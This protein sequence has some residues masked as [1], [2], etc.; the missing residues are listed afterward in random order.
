MALLRDAMNIAKTVIQDTRKTLVEGEGG[1]MPQR[2]RLTPQ[3]QVDRF[4]N[5]SETGHEALKQK[6]GPVKYDSYAKAMMSLA[7]KGI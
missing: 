2:N 6:W 7:R 5:M 1:A 3:Q 4:M